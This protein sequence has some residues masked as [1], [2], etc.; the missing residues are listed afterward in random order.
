[1]SLRRD[2][3]EIQ[4]TPLGYISPEKKNQYQAK[5]KKK[6]G[7]GG[8]RK[9]RHS[10][11]FGEIM[12]DKKTSTWGT[13]LFR[14]PVTRPRRFRAGKELL[15]PRRGLGLGE[16]ARA[17]V[18]G[19]RADGR[20]AHE[21]RLV[22]LARLVQETQPLFPDQVGVVLVRR[23]RRRRLVPLEGGVPVNVRSW[24]DED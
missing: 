4:L 13:H 5:K 12:G 17:R 23:R 10:G 6:K 3:W 18:L 21:E 7:G 19:V 24:V 22:A 2:S 14:V 1:M 11:G 8:G 20:D 16:G 9:K 15:V